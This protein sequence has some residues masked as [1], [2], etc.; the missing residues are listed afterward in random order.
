MILSLRQSPDAWLASFNAVLGKTFGKPLLYYAA[1]FIPAMRLGFML[2]RATDTLFMS[3]YGT[4]ICSRDAYIRHNDHVRRVVPN[5]RLLQFH[6][7]DGWEPLCKFLDRPVPGIAYAHFWDSKSAGGLIQSLLI[8]GMGI[9]VLIGLA[10]LIL[11]RGMSW[12]S[13]ALI[14][15]I[16]TAVEH[17]GC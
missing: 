14:Y 15:R 13:Y 2:H 9:W 17:S 4:T 10:T 6:A 7:T 16:A 1:F 12:A 11:V 3:R 5:R 8:R